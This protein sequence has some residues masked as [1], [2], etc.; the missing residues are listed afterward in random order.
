VQTPTPSGQTAATYDPVAGPNP[1]P[2]VAGVYTPDSPTH[3]S[4][5]LIDGW[6]M[7]L[8]GGGF[9]TTCAG[10]ANGND[11]LLSVGVRKYFFEL[12]SNAF[13]FLNC[14]T[15]LLTTPVGVGDNPNAPG[16]AFVNFMKLKTS[17]PM[18][19]GEARLSFGLAKTE[20]VEL[21]VYDVTGRETIS[22]AEVAAQLTRAT[23]RL[24]TYDAETL[25]QAYASRA[26]YGAADWE[27][28]GWVTSYL[29]VAVG[30]LDV[31][32]TAVADLSGHPP[33]SFH[34]L[35]ARSA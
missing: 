20:K 31:V 23:G 33:M 16:S 27:V 5:T 10:C 21:R 29:A 9:G 30:E 14:P 12:F 2:F 34:D 15:G 7:G 13:A 24:I 1:A 11:I 35:L 4:R 22:M 26:G 17:N 19:S 6:T 8:F 32:T 3:P 28:A 18:H 25:D